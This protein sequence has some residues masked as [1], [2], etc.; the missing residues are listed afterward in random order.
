MQLLLLQYN[1]KYYVLC[2]LDRSTYVLAKYRYLS[3][4]VLLTLYI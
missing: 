2:S 4:V 1:S 3:F